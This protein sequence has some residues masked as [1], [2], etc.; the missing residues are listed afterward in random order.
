MATLSIQVKVKRRVSVLTQQLTTESIFCIPRITHLSV[1]T[2]LN[3]AY[4]SEATL[5]H[6]VHLSPKHTFMLLKNYMI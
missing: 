1:P 4:K 5:R 3:L 2:H 6:Q